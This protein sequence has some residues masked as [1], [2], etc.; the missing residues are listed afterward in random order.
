M[1]KSELIQRVS[2]RIGDQ[3]TSSAAVDIMVSEI[4]NAVSAGDKVSI[5]GFGT[6]EKRDRA[7]RT[8]RNP[9][10]GEPIQVPQTSVPVFR[11]GQT[12]KTLVSGERK[13]GGQAGRAQAAKAPARKTQ[14]AKAQP[15]AR[16]GR[17]QTSRSQAA[18]AQSSY[19]R[20]SY[21]GGR[22]QS[23]YSRQQASAK[24]QPSRARAR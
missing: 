4:E 10:T 20:S 9:R 24:R 22:G 14:T 21:A 16:A 18:R 2:A 12:F 15:K 11:P 7:P 17:A 8:S 3:K 23:S 6:F 1:N 19:A 5:S 13:P